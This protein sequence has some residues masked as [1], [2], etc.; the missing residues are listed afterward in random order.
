MDLPKIEEI[1]R[2]PSPAPAPQAL[3]FDGESLW[4]GSWETQRMYGI[5]PQQFTVFE[6]TEAPGK[7]VG[8]V[9]LGD[10]LRVICSEGG[11]A[12]NRFIHRFIPGHGFKVSEK[13]ECPEDT[14]SFLA[15]DG[16][17]LWVSQRYNKRVLELDADYQVRREIRAEAQIIGVA[18]VGD[19]LFLSTWHGKEGGCKIA[20]ATVERAPEY[21]GQLGFAAFGLTYDGTRFWANDPRATSIV[22]FSVPVG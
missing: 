19:A 15:F 14:G 4:M 16:S 17:R 13:V 7:P 21:I 20:R 2:L 10:E 6:E 18:W 11:E 22:A 3:A 9:A 8:A 1:M 5:Q 12:D